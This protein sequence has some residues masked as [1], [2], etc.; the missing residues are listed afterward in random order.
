MSIEEDER[1]EIKLEI[2]F[3][4]EKVIKRGREEG[5]EKKKERRIAFVS[6]CKV[7]ERFFL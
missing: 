7:N 1:K 6:I 5:N 4:N 3:A 2:N